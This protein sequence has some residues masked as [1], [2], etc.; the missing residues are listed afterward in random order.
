MFLSFFLQYGGNP[1]SSAIG[2]AVLNVIES[3]DLQGNATRVGDYLTELLNKQKAKHT[4]IGDIRC[5]YHEIVIWLLTFPHENNLS[6]KLKINYIKFNLENTE[7][8]KKQNLFLIQNPDITTV[9]FW[10]YT[11]LDFYTS[12]NK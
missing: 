11:F 9:N 3:E 2:L 6:Y 8:H 10:V 5:A 1:V 4:L 12:M 7:E